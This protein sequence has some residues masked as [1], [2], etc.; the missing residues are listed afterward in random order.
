MINHSWGT[1]SGGTEVELRSFTRFD[2]WLF[3]NML[4]VRFLEFFSKAILIQLAY[5]TSISCCILITLLKSPKFRNFSPLK[6]NPFHVLWPGFPS[7]GF[8]VSYLG[9]K[10]DEMW[11]LGLSKQSNTLS[12]LASHRATRRKGSWCGWDT[13]TFTVF[14]SEVTMETEELEIWFS[15]WWATLEDFEW[16]EG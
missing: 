6:N 2:V 4:G 16:R 3:S 15:E 12:E 9:L 5:Y 7:R 8:V 1:K 13:L 11:A 14:G 10:Q